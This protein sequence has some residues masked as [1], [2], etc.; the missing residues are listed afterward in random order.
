[1]DFKKVF[2]VVS[3][4]LFLLAFVPYIRAILAR[5]TEPEKASWGIWAAADTLLFIAMMQGGA[6]NLQIFAAVIAAT[7]VFVLSLKF[8]K[9]GWTL[10]DKIC[11]VGAVVGAALWWYF[12][13]SVIGV[14]ASCVVLL[15][16]SLPTF[17]HAWTNPEKE[18]RGAWMLFWLSCVAELLA[19]PNWNISE[20]GQPVTFFIIESVMV[21]LVW[22]RRRA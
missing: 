3:F 19:L 2:D 18:N 21:Y 22:V 6:F 1:M 4:T 12:G 7:G 13:E 5:T 14:L 10:V 17:N 9:S 8:G 11:A 15:V 16:G 20:A